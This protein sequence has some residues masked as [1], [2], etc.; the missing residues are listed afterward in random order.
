MTLEETGF[1]K[2]ESGGLERGSNMGPR[3][4]LSLTVLKF[5]VPG[6]LNGFE[7]SFV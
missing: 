7:F 5:F 1:E 2:M 6:H 3:R 4:K